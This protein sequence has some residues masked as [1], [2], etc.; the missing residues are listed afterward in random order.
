MT[1]SVAQ[2]SEAIDALLSLDPDTLTDPELAAAVIELQRQRARLAAVAARLLA[3]WDRRQVWTGDKCR[4]AASRLAR[5]TNT[6]MRSARIE[7]RRARQLES[8][9]ATSTAI[10][11]GDLSLDHADLLGRANQQWRNIVFADHEQMLVTEC[12]KLRF[13]QAKRA[14]DYWCQRAD[15]QAA[16]SEAQRQRDRAHLFASPTLDGEVVVNG[17][18]DP[19]GGAIVV[20]ELN[21]LERDLYLADQRDGITRSGSQ[22]RA[23]ALVQMAT[24]SATVPADGKPPRPLFT[25]LLG[26]D[27]FTGMCELANGQVIIPGSLV[28]WL[29][30]ADLERIL[31]DG[32]STV[33]S[34]SRKRRFTGALRRAIQVR[35][36]HCQHPSG[37]DEPVDRCDVDHV[38][39]RNQNGPTSQFNGRIECFPHNRDATK[40]D[41]DA[42]PL[43]PRPVTRLDELRALIRWRTRH[44]YPQDFDDD[45]E[46]AG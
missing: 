4:S 17:V 20:D 15:A 28:P 14:V 27:S 37:C 9:P 3:R 39:P 36:R 16:E 6:S 44:Y 12:A 22:R 46:Q 41:H 30:T 5:D 40:H 32:P 42:T 29:G 1:G 24:R 34:V 25:V 8:M 11:A 38:V 10:A 13:S 45:D 19:I 2:L 35:D 31:F 43:P 26:D 18:L 23:A 21:R 7:L 33:I